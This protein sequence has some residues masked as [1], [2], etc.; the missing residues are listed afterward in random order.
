MRSRPSTSPRPIRSGRT[1][2]SFRSGRAP[3]RSSFPR[4]AT[5]SSTRWATSP[6][7]HPRRPAG[8]CRSIPDAR[9]T[10]ARQSGPVPAGWTAHRPAIGESVRVEVPAGIGVPTTG[11]SC[12]GRQRHGHRI[13][14]RRI[15]AGASDGRCA[16]PNVDGQLRRRRERGDP[17]D[18]AP[19]R[20]RNHQRLH[21]QHGAH[22]GRRHGIHHRRHSTRQRRRTVRAGDTHRVTTTAA[23]PRIRS[24]PATRRSRLRS[25]GFLPA[26]R[27]SR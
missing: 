12:A 2:P 20:R 9:S 4:A 7:R 27:R 26:P 24:T 22:R 18:R 6:R 11:V 13:R 25:P 21:V 14:W 19:W 8:S 5:S 15:P 1:S 10:P 17:R 3:S 23:S 16:R